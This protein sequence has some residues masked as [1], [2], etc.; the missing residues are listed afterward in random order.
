MSWE[1]D[2]LKRKEHAEFLTQ[3]LVN[4]YSVAITQVQF[5]SFVLGIDAEWGYGKTYF[6]KNWQKD[7]QANNRIVI[8][9]DAW[10]TDFSNEPL[11][12]F[13][14]ELRNSLNDQLGK[15][16]SAGKK[17]KKLL[18][19]GKKLLKPSLP[20]LMSVVAKNLTGLSAEEISSLFQRGIRKNSLDADTKA[21]ASV[22]EDGIGNIVAK[23]TEHALKDYQEK[24]T[25]IESFHAGLKE[26][27]QEIEKSGTHKIPIFILVDEL[28]RCRPTYAIEFLEVV[29]H[30]F[31]VPGIYFVIA[32]DTTQLSHSVKAIYGQDFDAHR[33]LKRFF[34]QHYHLPKPDNFAFADYL[35]TKYGIQ[36]DRCFSPIDVQLNN[37]NYDQHITVFALCA[38]YFNL[39]LRDQEQVCTILSAILL[40]R[41]PAE[42]RLHL[43]YVLVLINL[44]HLLPSQYSAFVRANGMLDRVDVLRRIESFSRQ[45]KI[46]TH[47]AHKLEEIT[48]ESVVEYYCSVLSSD[49]RTISR[50]A[51]PV[52]GTFNLIF[53]ELLRLNSLRDSKG[54][55]KMHHDLGSYGDLIERAGNLSV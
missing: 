46:K 1:D 34:D 27:V 2:K 8:Y 22:V 36:K 54:N 30:L 16:S 26:M 33:Y 40:L 44:R 28:D 31:G 47:S 14:A 32:T 5:S 3:Y 37:P 38:S 50:G 21:T 9:F 17:V 20:F 23:A 49:L 39:S 6:M 43:I 25:S 18:D 53:H 15:S 51:E 35:F 11:L 55:P 7:L 12:S 13:I 45:N 19:S 41:S 10:K 52:T 42:G 29:K 48:F 24:S 4:K